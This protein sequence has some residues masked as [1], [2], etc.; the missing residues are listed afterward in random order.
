MEPLFDL[1]GGDAY[2]SPVARLTPRA[3]AS[4]RAGYAHTMSKI[5]RDDAVRPPPVIARQHAEDGGQDDGDGRGHG[6]DGAVD[7][8]P[9]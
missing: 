5:R 8:R 6:P 9:P 3:M 4:K 1:D 2:P 7:V